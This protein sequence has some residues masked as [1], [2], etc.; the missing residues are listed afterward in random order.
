M[1]PAAVGVDRWTAA[2]GSHIGGSVPE[3]VP[4]IYWGCIDRPICRGYIEIVEPFTETD[5]WLLLHG[6][7]TLTST[8]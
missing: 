2:G 1:F 6:S 5:K 8:T 7:E 4:V 3:V